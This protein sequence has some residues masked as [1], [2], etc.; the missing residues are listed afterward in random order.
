MFLPAQSVVHSPIPSSSKKKE[1]KSY[2]LGDP[3][4]VARTKGTCAAVVM[5]GA[6]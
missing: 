2:G 4:G 6:E 5:V 3:A 1:K